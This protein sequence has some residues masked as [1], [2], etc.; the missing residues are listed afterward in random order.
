MW[1]K[2]IRVRGRLCTLGDGPW[3]L[4]RNGRPLR[5]VGFRCLPVSALERRENT[6]SSHPHVPRGGAALGFAHAREAL[7]PWGT[8]PSLP[9]RF[10]G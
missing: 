6:N 1:I 3:W 2:T 5:A 10:D 8:H 7:Y 4:C 9:G